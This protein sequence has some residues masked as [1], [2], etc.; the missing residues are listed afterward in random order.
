MSYQI[1]T[2]KYSYFIGAY[3]GLGKAPHIHSHLE[4]VYIRSGRAVAVLENR[5]YELEAGRLF[6]AFPNQI[7]Y[8][9]VL[10]PVQIYLV[11]FSASMHPDLEKL[12]GNK[13][14]VCPVI[15]A[16]DFEHTLTE[17]YE[18]RQSRDP[19][20]RLGVTGGLLAFFSQIL[21]MFSYTPV[22]ADSDSVQKIVA[23]CLTNFTQPLSLDILAKELY[24]S[25][26][27]ISHVFH[28]RMNMRFN[29]FINS[30]RITQAKQELLTGAAISQV[31]LNVGFSSIR[32]FN[33]AFREFTGMTPREYI[34]KKNSG[35]KG[36]TP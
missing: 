23:Y 2:K 7:H 31:A 8:Y 34:Q 20:Q 19:Y 13:V 17:L 28:K 24:L 3:G 1:Q 11:I 15:H 33:R 6:L 32:T 30:L 25:R 9:E 36:N 21:P 29:Q 12:L 5:R 16:A 4:L 26:Y 14:P 22:T 18:K 27:Y 35:S 10:E